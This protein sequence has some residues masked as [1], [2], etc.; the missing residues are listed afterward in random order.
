M[1]LPRASVY[2]PIA[3]LMFFFS[4]RLSIELF[5][6]LNYP[7][8]MI[9][10]E[11]ADASAEEVVEFVTRPLEEVVSSVSGVKRVSSVSRTGL[12]IVMVE[13]YWG[14]NMDYASLKV[15]EKLDEVRL[16]LPANAGRPKLLHLRGERCR[17]EA[18]DHTVQGRYTAAS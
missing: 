8:L 1:S 18:V 10:T 2:H 7:G 14:T 6:E 16:I 4:Q 15:R 12:S 17:L 11:Y 13:F 3:T 5:P 9:R